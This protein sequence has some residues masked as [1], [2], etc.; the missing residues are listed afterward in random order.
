MVSKYD[1][2]YDSI[3]NQFSEGNVNAVEVP[4]TTS[5]A[6]KYDSAYDKIINEYTDP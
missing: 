3:L 2:A 5:V 4:S 1:A 6:S